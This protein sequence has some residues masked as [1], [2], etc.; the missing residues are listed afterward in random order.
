MVEVGFSSLPPNMPMA[1]YVKLLKLPTE[2]NIKGMREMTKNDV[3]IVH[4][5]LNA[6]LS[7]FDVHFEFSV[8]EIAHFMLPRE[9]VIDAYVIENEG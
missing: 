1:R 8:E 3:P 2:V 5:L 4:S 7:K 6:Y 9:G